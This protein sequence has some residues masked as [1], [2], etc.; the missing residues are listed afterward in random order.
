MR[1]LLLFFIMGCFSVNGFSQTLSNPDSSLQA[2]LSSLGGTHLHLQQATDAALKNATSVRKAEAAWL[3]SA[4]VVRR[5]S[6]AFDPAL[7]YNVNYLEQDIPTASYFSGA[8]VLSTQQTTSSGG[9]R[10]NL[11]IG[12]QLQ[13]ALNTVR[14]GTNSSFASLNPEYDAFTSISVRQPLLGGLWVSGRKQLTTAERELDA[15]KARYDQEVLFVSSEVE[16]SYWDLYAAER[17]Y[18]VQRLTVDRAVAFL[19]EANLREHA[20]LVGPS[21]VASAKSFLAEQQLILLDREEALGHQSDALASLIGIRPDTGSVRFVASDDPPADFPLDSVEIL[22]RQAIVNNLDLQAAQH[23]IDAAQA[24]ASA[25]SWEALPSVNFVGSLGGSGLAGSPQNVIFNGD[26]LRTTR[27]GA[28]GDAVTQA[29][30]RDYP[31]WSVGVE[32]SIPIGLRSGLGEKDRLEAQVLDAQETYIEKSRSL[33]ESVRAAYRELSNGK[34]RFKVARDG[35]DATGEQVR[36]GLIEFRNGRTNAFELTRLGEDFGAAQSRYSEALVHTAKAA[37]TL[38][39]LTS[40][41]YA[42]GR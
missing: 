15:Q 34:N 31:N 18:G 38:K 42:G 23:D 32:V 21:E 28:F 29:V 35:V 40:G 1:S 20:G 24:L 6:G 10:M 19:D 17:D 41:A 9:L 33:E 7:F 22:V 16:L 14:L 25:A 39:E 12:T 30:H 5:E 36:I 8:P 27:E 2:I 37:A 4:G 26:T 11:A 3:A 13:V